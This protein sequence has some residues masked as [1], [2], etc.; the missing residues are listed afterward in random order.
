MIYNEIKK[1]PQKYSGL[2]L[3]KA[4]ENKRTNF[5]FSFK[6]G[7]HLVMRVLAFRRDS[8]KNSKNRG[9]FKGFCDLIS[10]FTNNEKKNK[11]FFN[12]FNNGWEFL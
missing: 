1:G 10:D 8:K 12:F 11:G 5:N 3:E 2:K 9:N 7:K 4:F 6:S